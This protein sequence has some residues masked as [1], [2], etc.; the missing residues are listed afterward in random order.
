MHL[1]RPAETIPPD[2]QTVRQFHYVRKSKDFTLNSW[3]IKDKF[4]IPARKMEEACRMTTPSIQTEGCKTTSS[5]LTVTSRSCFSLMT[6]PPSVLMVTVF[7]HDGTDERL[8]TGK[9]M[10]WKQSQFWVSVF[11]FS[12]KTSQ[13]NRHLRKRESTGVNR[14]E[15]NM[16]NMQENVQNEIRGYEKNE[17]MWLAVWRELYSFW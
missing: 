17:R 7:V 15:K 1:N 3:Q 10:A 11:F 8:L 13:E 5:P 14:N 12:I 2:F 16:I 6:S 4:R 9:F